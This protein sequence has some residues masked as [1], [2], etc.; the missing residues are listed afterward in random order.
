M[1]LFDYKCSNKKCGFT[2][3]YC[4][5]KSVP[6]DM[7]PP[8]KCPKCKKGKMEKQF[9]CQG[10][11]NDIPGGKHYLPG[12]KKNWKSKMSTVDQSRVILGELN[13]Y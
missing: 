12:C 13:P 3:E 4:T 7:N 2:D 5:N 1:P 11:S 8:D 10:Q 9:S 6:K